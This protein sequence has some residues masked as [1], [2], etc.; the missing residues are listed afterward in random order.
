M[1][2]H[3]ERLKTHHVAFMRALHAEIRRHGGGYSEI[4]AETG[5][6]VQVLMNMFNPN[7][8]DT[9]PPADLLLDVLEIVQARRAMNVLTSS[10]G[11]MLAP[12]SG[13]QS[14]DVSDA[15]AFQRV[16]HE[17]G[18]VLSVGTKALADNQLNSSE[19]QDLVREISEMIDAAQA[20]MTR[21]QG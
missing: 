21:L 7:N 12:I 15:T 14:D 18:D 2:V 3:A 5:R 13:E 1:A 17:V 8:M 11:M 6:P 20:F 19:R 16:V 4:A 9:A 10:M